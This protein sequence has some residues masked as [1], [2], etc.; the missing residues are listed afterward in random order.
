MLPSRSSR[1]AWPQ[2]SRRGSIILDTAYQQRGTQLARTSFFFVLVAIDAKA[3][4][5]TPSDTL[6]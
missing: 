2:F 6:A 3:Y 1:V 5:E 4:T